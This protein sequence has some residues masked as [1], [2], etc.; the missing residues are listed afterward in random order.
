MRVYLLGLF[1]EINAALDWDSRILYGSASRAA[2]TTYMLRLT[3]R[4]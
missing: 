4:P 3:C 1:I 2:S